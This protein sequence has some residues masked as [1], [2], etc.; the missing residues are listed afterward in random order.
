MGKPSAVGIMTIDRPPLPAA[1]RLGERRSCSALVAVLATTLSIAFAAV[2]CNSSSLFAHASHSPS[3]LSHAT[4]SP[5][6][7]ATAATVPQTESSS[8]EPSPRKQRWKPRAGLSWQWQLSV[9]VDQSFNVDVYDIDM[10]ENDADVVARL[11][12]AGRKV[13]CYVDVGSSE[14]FRPDLSKFPKSVLGKS[15]GWPGERWLDIR[16]IDVLRPIMAAR[17]DLCAQRG[18]DGVEPD[19]MDGYASDTGFP[20]TAADQLKYDLM[21]A[22]L[23]HERGLA[24]GL[25]NDLAQIPELVGHF[26]F[27]VNEQ[28]AQYS[29]C[30]LLIPFI[31]AGKPVFHTEY[32]LPKS[33]FCEQTTSLGFSSMLKKIELGP[34]RD[35][36]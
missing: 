14:N 18:F 22:G 23:G 19:L 3:K 17:F 20:I 21:I 1:T 6:S 7:T 4:R 27:A 5:Q 16:R 26:E 15:D 29:E 8:A 34:W 25:K 13:I 32:N 12:A 11:H 35:P 30:Q 2:G 28:C 33:A 24:V 10:F 31:A 36:C 9:P